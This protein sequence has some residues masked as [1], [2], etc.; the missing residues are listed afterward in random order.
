MIII[1]P[2]CEKSFQVDNNQIPEKG[3]FLKC[4]SCNHTWFFDYTKNKSSSFSESKDL[5]ETFSSN[6]NKTTYTYTEIKKDSSEIKDNKKNYE[7]TKYNKKNSLK[8]SHLLSY[9]LVGIIS[10]VGV[11]IIIDTF[12]TQLYRIYPNLEL[13]LFNL[14]ETLK[15]IELFIK[16]LF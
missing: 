8:F 15:D 11:I 3:R 2:S 10:F 4:G 7:I 6:K 5:K 13:I 1:C 12:S 14:F 16:D 9:L